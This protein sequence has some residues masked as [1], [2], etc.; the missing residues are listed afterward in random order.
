MGQIILVKSAISMDKNSMWGFGLL[1]ILLAN[2]ILLFMPQIR[3]YVIFGRED[4]LTQIGWIKDILE[5]GNIGSNLYPAN[6]ILL[7]TISLISNIN[8]TTLTKL[9]PPIYSYF[10]IVSC[11]LLAKQFFAERKEILITLAFISIPLFGV[12]QLVYLFT[13]FAMGFA[14][15]PFIIYLF[16]RSRFSE[17]K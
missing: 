7:A 2:A 14:L 4:V 15:L 11:Y 3:G 17:R 12:C 16:S 1:A 8:I 5:S 6:H 9:I 13:P 10:F